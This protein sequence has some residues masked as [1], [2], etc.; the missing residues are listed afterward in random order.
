LEAQYRE[1]EEILYYDNEADMFSKIDLCLDSPTLR[2][3]LRRGAL[4]RTLNEH[5]YT[6]RCH[7]LVNT[8]VERLGL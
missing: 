1:G 2:E 5:T 8:V 3:H 4:Q 6:H 7:T